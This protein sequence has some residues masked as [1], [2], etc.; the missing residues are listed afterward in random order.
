MKRFLSL[1]LLAMPVLASAAGFE[2]IVP[3]PKIAVQGKGYMHVKAVPIKC[4]AAIGADAI[5]AVSL[6]A[7]R[8]SIASGNTCPVSSPIGL[9]ASVDGGKAKGVFFLR[10][11][12]IEPEHYTIDISSGLAVIRANSF[13]GF[14]YSLQTLMQL[15]PEAIYGSEQQPYEKWVLP[16]GHIEDGPRFRYRGMHLDC[17]RHFWTIDEIKKYIDVM[18]FYKMNRFHWHLTDD[19]GWRVEIKK[20][21]L[22]TQISCWR[23]GTAIGHDMSSSD[24]IRYGGYYSQGNIKD[25]VS[26]AAQRGITIVPEIDLPG[27]MLAAMAAYPQ[28]GC[29]GGPYKAWTRWGVSEQVLCPAK[30]STFVF[31]EN[32]LSEISALFPGEYIHIGGDECP[33]SEWE[34]CPDCQALIARLGLKDDDRFTAEQYLQCYVTRR[35]QD[36]LSAKGKKIIGW[37]EI[38]EGELAS[39]ATVM[40]WRGASGGREAAEKGFDAIMTPNSHFYFDYCQA[41]DTDREPITIGGCIPVEK[42]YEFNPYE[43]IA[44]ESYGHILGV[45]A[46]LWTEYIK[47]NEHL[48]YMLLPRLLAL[49]EVQWCEPERKDYSRF[50]NAVINHEF[51]ILDIAG[52]T[53]AKHMTGISGDEI[54]DKINFEHE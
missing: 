18:A 53:Y 39:G 33:K 4:D 41:E 2:D 20:Y 47:T 12:S 6:F 46:N 49:S 21:P 43:G 44:P 45:Q 23:D 11:N 31:L 51:K 14:L 15:L 29:S 48:E 50:S 24:Q 19:Q 28:L 54:L 13:N 3:A 40:S 27:H 10:D 26:Y 17:S 32:V 22:L 30:E 16:C 9:Q 34:K 1:L 42:V 5:Q 52:Y 7:S 25:I 38:L 35:V 36:F 37:D 8:L